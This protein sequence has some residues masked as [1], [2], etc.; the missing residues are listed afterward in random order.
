LVVPVVGR[1]DPDGEDLLDL[2]LALA[3]GHRTY[4][5]GGARSFEGG[6]ARE[7]L[8]IEREGDALPSFP[9]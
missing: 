5:P 6:F 8:F 4:G 7:S 3:N 9:E 1:V 2:A